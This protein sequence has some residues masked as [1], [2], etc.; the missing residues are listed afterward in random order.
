M[1]VN[2]TVLYWKL[3]N[4]ITL[5]YTVVYLNLIMCERCESDFELCLLESAEPM[6][7]RTAMSECKIYSERSVWLYVCQNFVHR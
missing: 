3:E 5:R 2:I 7:G 1:I 4:V 6:N